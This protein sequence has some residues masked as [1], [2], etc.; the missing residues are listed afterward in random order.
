MNPTSGLGAGDQPF[1]LQGVE[2]Q[3]SGRVSFAP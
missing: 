3:R 1:P 2:A